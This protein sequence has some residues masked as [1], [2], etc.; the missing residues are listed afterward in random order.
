MPVNV[1]PLAILAWS[2][3]LD[4]GVEGKRNFIKI[5]FSSTV[6]LLARP[7]SLYRPFLRYGNSLTHRFFF[8]T[9]G[10]WRYHARVK[11]ENFGRWSFLIGFWL[12][13]SSPSYLARVVSSFAVLTSFFFGLI[14]ILFAF[15]LLLWVSFLM[16]WNLHFLNRTYGQK[17]NRLNEFL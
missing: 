4:Y 13:A 1:L 10:T 14:I 6:Y 17:K 16:H 5:I 12:P 9:T 2:S 15:C 8:R 11:R 7:L 3:S